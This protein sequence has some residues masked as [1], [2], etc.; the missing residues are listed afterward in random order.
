MLEIFTEEDA[1]SRSQ[2][3]RNDDAIVN[4]ASVALGNVQ[5]EFVRLD[6]DRPDRAN[7]ANVREDRP[8]LGKAQLCL[9]SRGRSEFVE[10]LDADGPAPG[11]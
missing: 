1:A 10:D 8:D 11:Q 2:G 5:S 7:P 6:I 9:P 4:R 3:G